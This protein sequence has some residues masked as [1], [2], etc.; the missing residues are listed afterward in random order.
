MAVPVRF[1]SRLMLVLALV[2]VVPVLLLGGLSFRANRDELHRLVGGLQTQAATDLARSCRQLV[3]MGVD[4]LRLAA[5]Y[6]PLEQL[7]PQEASEVLSIPLRQLG[8]FNLLVL[9]D[10]RGHAIAPAVFS[11]EGG[12]TRQ[13]VTDDSLALFSRQ[14]PVQAA[15]STGAAIG[16][17]YRMHGTSGGRVALAVRAGEDASRLLLAELSL[18]EL[19]RRVEELAQEGGLAFIVDAQ[20]V[21]VASAHGPEGL[22]QEER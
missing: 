13:H 2:G 17:P 14:A 10:A 18:G 7:G 1:V 22:S 19:G 3:L 21:P 4:N 12:G 16:P 8:A 5:E 11:P 20:G 15:L 6:L 9:V